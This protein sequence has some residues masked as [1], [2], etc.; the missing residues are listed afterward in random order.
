MSKLI[1]VSDEA[2]SKLDQIAHDTGLSQQD[3]FNKTIINLEREAILQKSNE[4]YA[5]V[6]NDPKQWQEEQE[7]LALWDSTLKDGLTD[8]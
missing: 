2:Y 7:E 6:K 3:I 4:T 1:R 5:A 8:L